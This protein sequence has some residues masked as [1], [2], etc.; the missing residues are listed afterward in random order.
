[1]PGLE[2]LQDLLV[3][4]LQERLE[5]LPK[6]KAYV[7][8]CRGPYCVYADRAVQVLRRSG[9]KAQRLIDGFPEWKAAGL[10]IDESIGE[11]T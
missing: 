5:R 11:G 9:R 3:H 7:A 8:Y 6:G 4:E 1:M 10:P 2:T